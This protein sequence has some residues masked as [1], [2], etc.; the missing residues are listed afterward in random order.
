MKKYLPMV[1]VALLAASPLGL[2]ADKMAAASQSMANMSDKV[3]TSDVVVKTKIVTSYTLN[4]Q[5]NP[6]D[7]TVVA[8]SG[9]V[10]LTGTVQDE[11]EKDLAEDIAK[12]VDGVAKVINNVKIEKAAK[13][14]KK[15]TFTQTVDDAT[16]T[17]AVKSKL[18]MDSK[19]NGLSIHVKTVN[20]MVTL[21]GV[22][23]SKD[24]KALAE[25]LAKGTDGAAK[26]NNLL[27]V[28]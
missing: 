17:A 7:I 4:R 25:K 5:L 15:P 22:V 10:T 13:R 18:L 11:S 28:K 24:E 14:G 20:N 26:V 6:F 1:L 12:S 19:T 23:N 3:N 21:T 2:A 27:S 8:D 9:T 16:T